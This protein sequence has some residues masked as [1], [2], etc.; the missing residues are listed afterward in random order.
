MSACA[1][2][3]PSGGLY[4]AAAEAGDGTHAG[5]RGHIRRAHW[6]GFRSG[7]MKTPAG[8][9]IPAELRRFD[10]RWL[11]PIPVNLDDPGQPAGDDPA[12]KK[13]LT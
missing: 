11:P 7:A 3:R 10:V 12:R 5:P 4:S 6:H 2:G 9:P 8:D 13:S 1:S